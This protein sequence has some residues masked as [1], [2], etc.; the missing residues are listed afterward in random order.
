MDE[1]KRVGVFTKVV[2]AQSFSEA[3][4][5][6]GV[7]KSAVSKQISLLEEEVGVRLLNRSTRKLSLTEAG[8]IYYRHC[9]QIV[10]RADIALNELR[11]YQNQPTGTIRVS[12]PIPFGR[13]LLIPVIKEL[14]ELYPLLK[15]ELVLSDKVVNLVE[16]GIDLV[17]RVGK[18][19]DSTL[20]AKKLCDTPTVVFA[21]PEYIARNGTPSTPQQLADHQ[22]I[23]LS[24]LSAPIVGPFRHKT[25]QEEATHT[26]NSHLKINS[27]DAVIDAAVQGLGITA[28][29]KTTVHE[30]LQA[31]RL[32][33]VL[34]GYQLEPRGVYA[35]YPHREFLPP[36]VRI[37]MSFLEKHCANASWS[38]P[39]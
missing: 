10:N 11:Q 17:V 24:I 7:A 23:T 29:V 30:H 22:W 25:S 27:V 28:M 33:P 21:S 18:L 1:L 39:R 3:A 6:L 12:S 16:E 9:E 38:L 36:K 8:E 26:V 32:V 37:F 20:I 2:Q 5:R 19:Q 14:R 15:V 31:G 35:L 4:R 34:E 13:A